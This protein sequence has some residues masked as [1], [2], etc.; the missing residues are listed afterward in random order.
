M[1]ADAEMRAARRLGLL[2][3]LRDCPDYTAPAHLLRE[4]LAAQGLAMS[5]DQ[6][7]GELAWCD[8]QGLILLADGQIPVASLTLHGEDAARGL[9]RVPGVARP[10]P[11]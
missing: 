5:M 7:R 4:R 2:Q 3:L 11:K 10:A 9:T 1:S 6:L 8:E